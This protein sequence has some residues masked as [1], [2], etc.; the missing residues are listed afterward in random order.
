MPEQWSDASLS[1]TPPCEEPVHA[2]AADWKASAGQEPLDPVQVSATS[3]CPALPRQVNEAARYASTQE[4]A[5]PEQWSA[6]S[7]SHTPPCDDPVHAVAAD[8]KASAGQEPL[9]PVQV[10]ATSQAPVA[11][12]QVV[13]AASKLQVAEQQ[14]PATRFPSSQ[15]SLPARMPSPQT[16]PWAGA[17]RTK[18]PNRTAKANAQ[19]E[20]RRSPRRTA[21]QERIGITGGTPC[22]A[23]AATARGTSAT[24]P[25]RGDRDAG[26]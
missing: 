10:S 7:S 13:P 8:W 18:A 22:I 20:D 23:L 4:S 5:L 17:V 3:H 14:S 16:T 1:H 15:L 6:A 9:D 24:R 12:R 21:R 19:A 2:V 25:V 26:P 11:A